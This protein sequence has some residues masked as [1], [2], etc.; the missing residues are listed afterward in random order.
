MS[1]LLPRGSTGSDRSWPAQRGRQLR[2][3]SPD[4]CVAPA[5]LGLSRVH[6]DRYGPAVE[7]PACR[8]TR[9]RGTTQSRSLVERVGQVRGRAGKIRH[10][11]YLSFRWL[12]TAPGCPKHR[13][14][15][16]LL[17][18]SVV[19]EPS[20]CQGLACG[21]VEDLLTISDIGRL[22]GVSRQRAGQLCSHDDFPTPHGVTGYGKVWKRADVKK[23]AKKVGRLK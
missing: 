18:A 10:V 9:T 1:R 5:Q 23:W 8:E 7:P 20:E 21:S 12:A 3:T 11:S 4:R 2:E 17:V 15:H 14:G 6:P 22:L 13:R 19:L 16:Y